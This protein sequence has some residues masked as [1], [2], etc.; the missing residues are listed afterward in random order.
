VQALLGLQQRMDNLREEQHQREILD[1]VAFQRAK[2]ARPAA[3]ADER[4]GSS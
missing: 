2:T 3:Q 1:K 4:Q